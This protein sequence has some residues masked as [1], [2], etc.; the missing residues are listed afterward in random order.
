MKSP[1]SIFLVTIVMALYFG[2]CGASDQHQEA[3]ISATSIPL[4]AAN[5]FISSDT[6]SNIPDDKTTELTC[7][8]CYV[9]CTSAD[10]DLCHWTLAHDTGGGRTTDCGGK[11]DRWCQA[12]GYAHSWAGCNKAQTEY[13]KSCCCDPN[14]YCSRC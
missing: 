5:R 14:G 3:D 11:G 6:S 13:S 10:P 8:S 2:A 7:N 4:T 1:Q 12:R 9:R